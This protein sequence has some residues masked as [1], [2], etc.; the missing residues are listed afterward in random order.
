MGSEDRSPAEAALAGIE[1][2][3]ADGKVNLYHSVCGEPYITFADTGSSCRVYG[4]QIKAVLTDRVWNQRHVLLKKYEVERIVT[5]LAGMAMR[6][7]AFGVD[8][9]ELLE[10]MEAE[11]V[12]AVVVEFADAKIKPRQKWAGTMAKLWK[13]LGD[14]SKERGLTSAG[15]KRFPGGAH[16]LSRKLAALK[17]VLEQMGITVTTKRSNGCQVTVKVDQDDSKSR[18]SSQPSAD[19]PNGHKHLPRMDDSEAI[20]ETLRLRKANNSTPRSP[21]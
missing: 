7:P 17:A 16:V 13:E 2:E 15:G 18:S 5:A 10:L 9:P 14:F 8:D 20:F 19:N 4:R 12:L 21:K 3:I 11:P 6:S 1:E